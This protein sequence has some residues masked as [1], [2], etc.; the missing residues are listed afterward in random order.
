ME[1][2]PLTLQG[3]VVR[4]VPLERRHALDL[5]DAAH[6]DIFSL[7]VTR[8]AAWTVEAFDAYVREVLAAPATCAFAVIVEETGR[9]AGVTT[10]MDIR[11]A[12]R[13]LEIGG[14]WIARHCQGGR[15]NPEMKYLLLRHAFEGLGM[16][17][18]QLK[19]DGRNL[20][21]QRAIEKLGATREGVLRKHVVLPDGYVRDSVMYSITDEEW[22]RVRAGL[23]ARLA[24]LSP[25]LAPIQKP[26]GS[27]CQ[28]QTSDA[29]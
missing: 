14:T 28:Q 16:L 27:T 4:L 17:R 2:E 19:T 22:P 12:H 6:P 24:D 11:L 9:A 18:V 3:V 15:V 10:Y 25:A 21:S 8:P 20:H 7:L 29:S 23:E 1:V 26:G 13:G 5:K